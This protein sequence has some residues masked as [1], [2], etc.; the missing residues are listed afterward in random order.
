MAKGALSLKISDELL[1]FVD[2]QVRK[3]REKGVKW[4]RSK[5][6]VAAIQQRRISQLPKFERE[7]LYRRLGVSEKVDD[8]PADAGEAGEGV[9]VT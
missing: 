2:S 6:V 1:S 8:A 4:D 3:K 5:E 9:E 7:E